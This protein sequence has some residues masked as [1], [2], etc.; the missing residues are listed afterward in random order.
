MSNAGGAK[1]T[2]AMTGNGGTTN[3]GNATNTG[4]TTITDAM[5]ADGGAT[6]DGATGN[7]GATTTGDAGPCTSATHG[8]HDYVFCPTPLEF[9]DART[10]CEARGMRLTRIDDAAE[11][12]FVGGIAF[13]PYPSG[14]NNVNIWPWFGSYDIANPIE[15]HWVDGTVFWEG[16]NNGT[17]VGG[18]YQNWASASPGDGTGVTC[19]AANHDFAWVD[20]AC[21]QLHPYVCEAY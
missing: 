1:T 14:Y 11:N 8:G 7:D 3:T 17:P 12:Q 4:G 21:T 6:M 2:D 20:R 10:D 9:A 15:W 5:T 18:M 19:I 16:R 13:A